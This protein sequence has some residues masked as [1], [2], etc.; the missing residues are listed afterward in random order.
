MSLPEVHLVGGSRTEAVRLAP[1]ATAMREQARIEPILLAAGSDP[2]TFTQTLDVFGLTPGLAV[3]AEADDTETIRRLDRLWSTRTPA[4]V[5]VQGDTGASLPAALA[6]YWRRIPVV[7]LDAGRRSPDLGCTGPVEPNRRLLTQVSTLHLAAAPLAAMNLLDEKVP[8]GDVLLTGNTA[9]D[10]ALALSIRY[11]GDRRQ[12]YADPTLA[13]LRDDQS[14]PNRLLV[15]GFEHLDGIA[16]ELVGVTVRRLA[17]RYPDLDVVMLGAEPSG[18]SRRVAGVGPLA[19]ADRAR[20]L[21][22]A[23]L[24]LT[25]DGDLPEEALAFGVPA[26]V[27]RE[28]TDRLELLAAGCVRIIGTEPET[29]LSEMSELLDSRVRRDAMTAPGNPYGDGLA[30]Q[31]AAQATA[32]L[33]GH[34]PFPE[35]MPARPQ[36]GVA[37]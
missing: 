15:V 6:A 30:A 27:L 21:A 25:D 24:V 10:A 31:R 16:L 14:V 29:M 11:R 3:P 13:A 20:L 8:A 32:A 18:R 7:H 4:A 22:E 33:L 1:I 5:V 26:L 19:Y 28:P 35:P 34:G 36:A 23:Y 12:P 9:V 37:H 17:T 2:L